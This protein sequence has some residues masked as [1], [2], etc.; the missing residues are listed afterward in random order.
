MFR[1][2]KQRNEDKFYVVPTSEFVRQNFNR[3]DLPYDTNWE[4]YK[5]FSYSPENFF[6]YVIAAY[7]AVVKFKEDFPWVEFYFEDKSKAE[8]FLNELEKRHNPSP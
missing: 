8:F 2:E 4:I 3:Y 1:I 5:L 6:K 7:N